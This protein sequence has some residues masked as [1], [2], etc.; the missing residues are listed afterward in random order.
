V[1]IE[2][3]N[4]FGRNCFVFKSDTVSDIPARREFLT[5]RS[6]QPLQVY[7][8]GHIAH[9]VR[10]EAA[11]RHSRSCGNLSFIQTYDLVV[12]RHCYRQSAMP[13]AAS[14]IILVSDEVSDGGSPAAPEPAAAGAVP[15]FPVWSLVRPQF[16]LASK[17]HFRS[18]GA[19]F[20][21]RHQGNV[22]I[23][24]REDQF[25]FGCIPY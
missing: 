5:A 19:D 24:Q 23:L 2:I 22:L 18:T 1:L 9:R 6:L 11:D 15:V 14:R 4:R 7:V 20:R 17:V 8:D 10:F 16:L 12:R 25:R 21:Q 13:R 3:Q